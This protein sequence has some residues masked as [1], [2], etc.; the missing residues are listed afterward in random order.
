MLPISLVTIAGDANGP[1][2]G[3][4]IGGVF[5]GCV[6]TLVIIGAVIGIAKMKGS[7]H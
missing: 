4:Y 7:K 1:I 2:A 6:G 3:A 5:T